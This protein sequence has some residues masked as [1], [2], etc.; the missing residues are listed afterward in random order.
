[1]SKVR[2]LPGRYWG[3]SNRSFLSD[4][5]VFMP[6]NMPLRRALCNFSRDVLIMLLHVESEVFARTVLGCQQ[7]QLFVR[8]EGFHAVKHALAQGALQFFQ[9]CVDHATSCRK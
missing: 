1:M 4:L 6:L 2:F 8:S 3:V 9:G 5:R 7:S